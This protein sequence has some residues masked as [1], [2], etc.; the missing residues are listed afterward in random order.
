MHRH[1]PRLGLSR[2]SHVYFFAACTLRDINRSEARRRRGNG[3]AT[4]PNTRRG[5][6]NARAWLPG[7]DTYFNSTWATPSLVREGERAFQMTA[8][9]TQRCVTILRAV[10]KQRKRQHP[11]KE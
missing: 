11:K 7:H 10:R 5:L 3:Q 1:S 8:R 9:T 4:W 6:D 2:L